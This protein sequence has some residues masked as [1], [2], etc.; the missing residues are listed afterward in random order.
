MSAR[1]DPDQLDELQARLLE[2]LQAARGAPVSFAELREIGIEN[3]ALLCYELAA[4][5]LPVTRTCSPAEGMP[6]LSVRLEPKADRHPALREQQPGRAE[7]QPGAAEA[8]DPRPR[9]GRAAAW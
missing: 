8:Q 9:R 5:G 1:V 4:V 7:E 6:A 2:R 3:P